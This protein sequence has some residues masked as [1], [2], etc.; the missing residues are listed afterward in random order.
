MNL[1]EYTKLQKAVEAK[2]SE[3]DQAVGARDQTVKQIK[4][5]FGCNSFAEAKKLLADL[6]EE[7]KK[8]AAAFEKKLKEFKDEWRTVVE[9]STSSS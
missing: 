8:A 6:E 9:G 4:D 1:P 3:I 5:E 2:K 7:E